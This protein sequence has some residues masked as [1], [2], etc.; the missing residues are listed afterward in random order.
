[1][2]YWI[3]PDAETELGDAAVYYAEHASRAIAEAFLVEF[4]RVVELL[5]ENQFCGPQGEFGFRV[6][7]LDRSPY[8][9]GM[10]VRRAR[11]FIA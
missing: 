11:R 3:H 4:E 5:V 8:Y 7:R 2:N 6:C 1:M 10:D 9:V